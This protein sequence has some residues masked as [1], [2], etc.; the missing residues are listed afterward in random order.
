MTD[1]TA[2]DVERLR[3]IISIFRPGANCLASFVNVPHPQ[4]HRKNQIHR[5][6]FQRLGLYV[7]AAAV[8]HHRLRGR[9]QTALNH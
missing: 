7:G 8:P 5:F 2:E 4:Q 6:K 1:E 9:V 3:S